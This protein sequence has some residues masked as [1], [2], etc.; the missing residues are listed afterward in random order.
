MKKEIIKKKVCKGDGV[1]YASSCTG[2]LPGAAGRQLAMF[3]SSEP[4]FTHCSLFYL[5]GIITST[6]PNYDKIH[7]CSFHDTVSISPSIIRPIILPVIVIL[8]LWV[9][10][11]RPPPTLIICIA[12]AGVR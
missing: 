11:Q 2:P 8:P 7:V 6:V 12:L 3:F 10:V 4:T 1:L 5:T 9:S